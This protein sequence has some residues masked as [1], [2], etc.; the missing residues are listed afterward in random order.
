M[1]F[2]TFLHDMTIPVLDYHHR[3]REWLHTMRAEHPVAY[4]EDHQI[5]MVFRYED[6]LRV[7][8][9][10]TTY[11][12]ASFIGDSNFPSIAGMDP[13][14]H[15][16]FRSLVTQAL[17]ARTIA[18][19]APDVETITTELFDRVLP[20][21]EMDWV[22][23]IAHPLPVLVIS[24]MLGLPREGWREYREWADAMVNQ[25]PGWS[26][27]VQNFWLLFKDAIEAHQR[28][29]QNDV[30]SLLIAAEVDGKR[31][32]LMELI[33]FCF[34]LFIAGY[35]NTA[36]VL[37]NAVLCFHEYPEVLEQVRQEPGLLRKAIE[38]VIRYMPPTQ[39]IPGDIKL[40][41]GRMATTDTYLGDQLIR[42]GQ[43]VKV[44]RLSVNFDESIFADPERFDIL[45][46]PNRHQTLGHGI[47]F[48]LGAPLARL[49]AR[50]ALETLMG[51]LQNLRV[52][53]KEPLL[54]FESQ[55]VFGPRYLPLAFQPGE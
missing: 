8:N 51:R 10:Y 5:W 36:N 32:N 39:E 30:L 15:T 16:Q 17:S 40:A 33:G 34:T 41:E 54:R 22:S 49:E 38:E 20:A 35:L 31:L 11:S 3:L 7:Q 14:R 9:D 44:N 48:C 12:S 28:E 37:G 45:R 55:L 13:P 6:G 50:I 24:K 1:H 27:A 47:H 42:K 19:M 4:D 52:V 46:S 29:P 26:L 53:Q 43:H 23:D 21:G 25:R 18:E 2:P